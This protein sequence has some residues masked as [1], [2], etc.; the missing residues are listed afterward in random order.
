MSNAIKY[1]KDN[2]L[3]IFIAIAVITFVIEVIFLKSDL[4]I[5]HYVGIA[6][7]IYAG[8]LREKDEKAKQAFLSRKGLTPQDVSNIQFVK[9]WEIAK[10]DGFIKYILFNGG[11]ITGMIFLIPLSFCRFLISNEIS[12]NDFG[13]MMYFIIECFFISYGTGVIIYLI[14][15]HYNQRRFARLTDHLN[16]IN[17][18]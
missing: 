8:Y 3:G 13:S 6:V 17:Y 15:W 16:E 2:L 11:L 12:F 10:N 7:V 9:D 4:N 1:L 5:T 18:K 14:R